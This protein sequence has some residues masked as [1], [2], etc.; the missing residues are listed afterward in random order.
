M[1]Q[2]AIRTRTTAAGP[3]VELMGEL[4][5]GSCPQFREVL[6]GLSLRP[7]QRLVIDLTGITLCDSS[8]IS[9][10]IAARNH[11]L[12]ARAA[13]ALAAVPGRVSRIL[14]LVGLSQIFPTYPTARA[15]E[16]AWPGQVS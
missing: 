3:V 15:A 9:V 8:G 14:T 13:I 11:A 12:A 1:T 6:P 4:D 10:L 2:L 5:H 16:A 7:G